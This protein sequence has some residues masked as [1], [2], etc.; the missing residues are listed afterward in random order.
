MKLLI[1]R[2]ANS[3]VGVHLRN[4]LNIKPVYVSIDK[5]KYP[6]S[7]SDAFL[8]RTDNGY[9]TIF[10]YSDILNLF[11]ELDDSWVEIHIY[12]KSNELIKIEK[13]D[14]LNLSNEFEISSKRLNGVEDFGVFYIYHFTKKT[15]VLTEKDII[16][17]RCYVGYSLNNNLYSFVHGNTLGSYTN[18][19]HNNIYMNNSVKTSLF[20]NQSYTLQKHFENFDRTELFFSN[21]TAKKLKVSLDNKNFEMKPNCSLVVEVN[22]SIITIKSNCYFLRPTVFSYRGKFVDVHHS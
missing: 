3:N 15:T 11:Y 17:N 22:N 16:S 21:P 10:K 1:K 2:L 5:K 14:K 20:K 13:I 9:S 6:L 19:F 18:T 4:Y 12:T 7:V 8:W